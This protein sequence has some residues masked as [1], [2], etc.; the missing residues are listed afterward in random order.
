MGESKGNNVYWQEEKSEQ[1]VRGR[2]ANY[3]VECLQDSEKV[4]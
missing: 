2:F 3:I 4:G 1:T